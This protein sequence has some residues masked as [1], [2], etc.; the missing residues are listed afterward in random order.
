LNSQVRFTV[1]NYI[2]R[3]SI[4]LF[5]ISHLSFSQ[6]WNPLST[7]TNGVVYSTLVVPGT[8]NQL[9]IGGSF[10][11][12]GGTPANRIA[13]WNGS[14]WEQVGNNGMDGTVY[15][16]A[17]FQGKIIAAGEF[18][19]AGGI[20]SNKI[21]QFNG[22]SWEPLQ[23]GMNDDVYALAIYFNALRAGGRFTTAGGI[24]ANRIASWDGNSWSA[25]GSGLNDAVYSLAVFGNDLI[26]GGKF[27]M[28][29]TVPANRIARWSD[30]WGALGAGMDDGETRALSV[31]AGK[32]Y[33][34]GTFT[35][36]GGVLVRHVAKWDGANWSALTTG[37]NN[38]VY[39]IYSSAS[40]GGVLVI[41]GM[42][43]NAGGLEANRVAVWDGNTWGTLGTGMSG[44]SSNVRSF[45]DYSATLHAAGNFPNAGSQNVN[46]VALWG[47]LPTAPITVSPACGST[48]QSL[49][50]LLDWSNVANAAYY[51]I[52][53]ASDP[54]FAE[55]VVDTTNLIQSQYQVRSGLLSNGITYY[56]RVR[57]HNG[58][59]AGPYSTIC[60]FSTLL[61][62]ISK[63]ENGIPDHFEL[64]QN[65][66]NPFNPRT[67][68]R[69]QLPVNSFVTLRVYN[70]LGEELAT[71]VNGKL[72]P[73][74]YEVEWEGSNF[75]S[76]LYLYE[77][78]ASSFQEVRKMIL[79]K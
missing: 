29:G 61:T 17:Y 62:G 59:G 2:V 40:I 36:I 38:S 6:T 5:S 69:Y 53:I 3:S 45:T 50:P 55:L 9:Y 30:F 1:V 42:F 72:P 64:Y 26:V 23:L 79:A 20:P 12:A 63:T 47:G 32:L 68:I 28:A 24:S 52:Q 34:G 13:R 25:M 15:A 41:G 70:V 51:S 74:I 22:N 37:T 54:N 78:T 14:S 71:L 58:I 39:A 43:T 21:A 46:N 7:G 27:T 48:G 31:F 65:F 60:W 44:D 4:V 35:M 56:W 49:T 11:T 57:A 16:L 67:L 18:F 77:I 66:P 76:G 10:T 75:P 19:Y 33:A 8:F 73:G